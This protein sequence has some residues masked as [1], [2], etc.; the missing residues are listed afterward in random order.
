MSHNSASKSIL[1][2]GGGHAHLQVLARWKKNR[3]QSK[4]TLVSSELMTPYSGMVPGYLLGF[5]LKNEIQID[6]QKAAADAGA[7]FIHADVIRVEPHQ[8]S[9]LLGSGESIPFDVA[10]LNMGGRGE[11]STS[12]RRIIQV[13]PLA[14]LMEQWPKMLE[15]L[16]N[17]TTFH[18]PKVFIVGGGAAG[19]ELSLALANLVENFASKPQLTLWQREETLASH[20]LQ[21]QRLAMQELKNRG[22]KVRTGIEVK[23][24]S[25]GS[26]EFLSVD[27]SRDSKGS[28][29]VKQAGYEEFDV[30]ILATPARPSSIFKESGLP[31]TGDGF[32]KVS[33]TLQVPG[34]EFLFGAGDSV[35]FPTPIP[36][37]GVYAVR[38]GQHLAGSLVKCV[39]GKSPEPFH[40]QKRSLSLISLGERR[41]LASYGS[42]GLSAKFLWAVKNRIDFQFINQFRK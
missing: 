24:W 34:F 20:S 4:V 15:N 7:A 10:S 22:I 18:P 17:W 1:L 8:K 5:Y 23:S 38:Q 37:S 36:H 33:E 29:G 26:L 11:L 6:L 9:V 2:I 12:D 14:N 19:F 35:Q 31:V 16:K 27:D 25:N 28:R 32:L 13:R 40:P 41:A 3:P 21:A 42:L 30:I 39:N